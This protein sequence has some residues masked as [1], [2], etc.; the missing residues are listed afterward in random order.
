MAS[1]VTHIKKKR[2][3]LFRVPQAIRV[4]GLAQLKKRVQ[5]LGIYST[6]PKIV[7]TG[8]MKNGEVGSD[9]AKDPTIVRYKAVWKGFADFCFLIG[10][11]DSA[12]LPTRALC[13]ERPPTVNLQTAKLFLQFRVNEKGKPL[14]D[15][16]TGK[17]VLD[18]NGQAVNCLGD[19]TGQSSPGLFRSALS[20]LHSHYDVT[21]GPYVEACPECQKIELGAACKGEGC[22]HHPGS[23]QYWHRGNVVK[24]EGFKSCV[25]EWEE[26]IVEHYEA[27]SS[28]QLM[29]GELQQIH[30]HLLSFNDSYHLMLWTIIIVG[31]KMFLC[32]E[33]ALDLTV[34]HFLQQYV[35]VYADGVKGISAK[36]KG[37][38]DKRWKYFMLWHD[39]DCPEFSAS[40]AV[41]IWMA[42]SGI[43]SGKLFTT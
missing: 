14:Q 4:N 1:Q 24:D 29:P 6:A 20:K 19:W 18:V 40:D 27:R 15:L 28:A 33:E 22:M 26:Y 36:I 35:Q 41:L 10:D 21:K 37:K 9:R 23:P 34:E 17:T 12:M 13:P 16:K 30:T 42:V 2:R 7:I 5:D 31:V 43:K 8:K 38:R 32:C 11:F 3:D 25:Q 39:K